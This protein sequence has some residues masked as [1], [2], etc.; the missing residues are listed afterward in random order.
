[1]HIPVYLFHIYSHVHSE[2]GYILQHRKSLAKTVHYLDF[3]AFRFCLPPNQAPGC[4][5]S[6]YHLFHKCTGNVPAILALCID[7]R[8]GVAV[9]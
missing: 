5:Y 4:C 1:M 7:S 6:E 3:C 2:S 9:Y 8:Q